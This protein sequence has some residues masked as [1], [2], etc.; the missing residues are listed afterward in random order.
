MLGT[1]RELRL[2][3][4]M[5]RAPRGSRPVVSGPVGKRD[6][7]RVDRIWLEEREAVQRQLALRAD[8]L[9]KHRQI[10]LEEDNGID[11]RR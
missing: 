10:E 6:S 3:G 7:L 9:E 8:A 2:G 5:M 1:F 4:W 11:G